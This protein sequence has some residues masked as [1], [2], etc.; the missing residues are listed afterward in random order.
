MKISF[1]N[2]FLYTNNQFLKTSF[3]LS[4]N[5]VIPYC[6]SS[7]FEI[8]DCEGMYIFP[9][10]VDVHVHLREPGF[11]YKETVETGTQAAVSSGYVALCTML[12]LN[13]VPDCVDSINKQ[14]DII[15]K[16]AKCLITR[17]RAD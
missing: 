4:D 3:S 10:F 6:D 16:D 8:Y 17:N 7:E 15:S 2:A 1:K 11:S 12:N 14:L 9:G 5:K 13:P